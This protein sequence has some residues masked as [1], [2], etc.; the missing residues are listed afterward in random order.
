M[1]GPLEPVAEHA[2][3]SESLYLRGG[4]EVSRKRAH[5][6]LVDLEEQAVLAAKVLEDRALGDIQLRSDVSHPGRVISLFSEVAH[7]RI[8]DPGTLCL[9]TG[10]GW[11]LIAITGRSN[12]TAGD[13]AHRLTS[14]HGTIPKTSLE[15]NSNFLGFWASVLAHSPSLE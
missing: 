11:N 10:A 7:G 1:L 8:D 6:L 12:K 15:F 2:E 14:S 4:I 5:R 3:K 13:S 9:R